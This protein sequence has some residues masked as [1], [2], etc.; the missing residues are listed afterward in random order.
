L[1]LGTEESVQSTQIINADDGCV[2]PADRGLA[3]GDGVFETMAAIDGRIRWLSKHMQRLRMSCDRLNIPLPDESTLAGALIDRLPP[4]GFAVAKLTIT[5]GSGPRGYQ[6]PAFPRPL[7]L[8]DVQQRERGFPLGQPQTLRL[9]TLSMRLGENPRLAGIKHLS[10]LE[11]VL[12]QAELS[13]IDA[14]EG[15]L[16]SSSGSVIGGI[17]TNLFCIH[18]T[19]LTT[20]QVNRAG[21][22]GVM[23]AVVLELAESAGLASSEAELSLDD[24]YAADEIFL[25]N[26]IK[27]PLAIE[28]LDDRIFARREQYQRLAEVMSHASDT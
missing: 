12:A 14:D 5:R 23:R 17:S 19:A 11:N 10:R 28:N 25:T 20:P 8:V 3:Y 22:A 16:L 1:L 24:V 15:L 4:R 21:V 7:I 2:D 26:A 13:G 27:G 6:P 9:R 18:G